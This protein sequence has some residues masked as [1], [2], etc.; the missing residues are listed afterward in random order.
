MTIVLIILCILLLLP[1]IGI[2]LE[3]LC[4][5]IGYGI[6]AAMIGG[7][8][9]LLII[10]AKF[11]GF[12]YSL[13]LIIAFLVLITIYNTKSNG[14][15]WEKTISYSTAVFLPLPILWF[16]P[17]YFIERNDMDYI[18]SVLIVTAIISSILALSFI[19]DPP[20][21]KDINPGS[22]VK[23]YCAMLIPAFIC[24]AI[25]LWSGTLGII[26]IIFIGIFAVGLVRAMN[27]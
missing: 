23:M 3:A 14:S 15:T 13:S 16:I 10:G 25:S 17:L 2:I 21:P 8:I 19:F 1:F 20:D 11:L 7:L 24:V 22:I 5:I 9:F 27:S 18:L 4:A 12:L 6:G 26:S